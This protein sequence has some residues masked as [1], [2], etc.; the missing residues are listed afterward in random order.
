MCRCY[1]EFFGSLFRCSYGM[2]ALNIAPDDHGQFQIKFLYFTFSNQILFKKFNELIE[3][4][5]AG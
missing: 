2:S 4:A 5:F 1:K 3:R